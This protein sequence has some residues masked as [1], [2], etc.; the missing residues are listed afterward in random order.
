MSDL[1]IHQKITD[2][3]DEL[4]SDSPAPGGGSAACLSGSMGAALGSMV[5]RLT[6]GKEGYEDVE[7]FFKEKLVKTEEL[8]EKIINLLDKD[9]NAFSGVIAAFRMPK[10]TEEEKSARSAKILEGYKHAT[11]VPLESCRACRE[12]FPAD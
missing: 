9:A 11:E 2:F 6:I 3:L 7:E 4:A 8:R 10:E 1:L 5:A 12:P